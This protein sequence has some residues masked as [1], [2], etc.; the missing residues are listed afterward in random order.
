MKPFHPL[1]AV[2]QLVAYL[3]EGIISGT[4]SQ[5][6]PGVHKLGKELGVS[7]KTV[8]AAVAKLKHE[9]FLKDQGAKKK[10][11]IVKPT[12][13]KSQLLADIDSSLRSK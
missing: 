13:E 6:L 8:V 11:L 1:S 2:D 9:G 7:P 4:L 3:R 10:S 5:T 12:G